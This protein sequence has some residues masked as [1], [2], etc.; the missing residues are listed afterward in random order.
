[1]G[2]LDFLR[3]LRG[4]LTGLN[5]I[6]SRFDLIQSRL[7][8]LVT[9]S[10]RVDQDLH[11]INLSVDRY[12]DEVLNATS[13]RFDLIQSR[14][15]ALVTTSARADKDLHKINKLQGNESIRIA[16]I[17]QH[18]SV[19]SSWR[20][21]WK[22]A[23]KDDRFSV[24]VVLTPFIHPFSSE[25]KTYDDMKQLLISESVPFCN[26]AYFDLKS[27]RPHVTF[28][29]NP[30][31]ETRPEKLRIEQLEKT[32]SRIAYI[33]YGLE[34]GGGTWNFK[35]QFD[36]PLHRSAWRVFARSER[37]E[38]MFG[39]YCRAGNGHVVV[40]GHPKFDGLITDFDKNLSAAL[41]AKIAGR[42]VILWTPH[43]SV[44]DPATWS[45]F[46]TYGEYILAEMRF[47]TDM[48]LLIRPHPMFFKAMRQHNLWDAQGEQDFRQMIDGTV[49]FALDETADYRTAFSV[50]YALMADVGSF[51]LEF[52]PTGKPIMYLHC[53]G[54]LGMNDD[55]ELVKYL[56]PAFSQ[57]DI[58]DFIEMIAR[59][60][61]PLKTPREKALPDFLFGLNLESTAGERICEHIYTALSTGDAWSPHVVDATPEQIQ[62]EVYWRAA[63]NTYLAPPD[64]YDRKKTILNETLSQMPKISHA[65]DIGCGDG[66]FTFE[67]AKYV[68]EVTGYDISLALVE[69][70]KEAAASLGIKNVRFV[71]QELDELAL[72]EKF[73][74]V[75]CMGVTSCIIDDVKFLAILDSFKMLSKNGGFLLMIDSLSTGQDQLAS[76]QS[77][78]IA[79]YRSIDD[80]RTLIARRGFILKTEI[81]IK[82]V[83]EK[84][85]V[86]KLFVFELSPT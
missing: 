45:T 15:D 55:G 5:A 81:P 19:W 16:F 79:K 37:H 78:Y 29:Q 14:L 80:Y 61:D 28:I 13:S 6:S 68:K 44:G 85:L 58:I 67:L 20:S 24:K 72:L 36:S 41:V 86:I 9:T 42:K 11:Q 73:D 43:F 84:C 7:D 83:A 59:G 46:K 69:N 35:A 65:I 64:Y 47:R 71:A 63:S 18:P 12:K 32:G 76:D 77:G 51:L 40:T 57:T 1:M 22:A 62:S 4:R 66:Q 56:Y 60:D 33:P 26:E 70:G 10:A 75:S 17:V 31:E 82:E 27:F 30:Y 8:A 25:A 53:D 74:L 52:L 50:A 34:M 48:F 38:K 49:N 2:I 3:S 54:G 23:S 39:K 21:V